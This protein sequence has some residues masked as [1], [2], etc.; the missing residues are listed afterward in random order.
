MCL[1]GLP[2]LVV[3]LAKNQ[4]PVARSLD[5]VGVARHIGSSADCSAAKLAT[6]LAKLLGSTETRI[7]MS[8]RGRELVDGRGASRVVDA[9]LN[10]EIRVRRVTE[11]DCRLLW[12]W[13]NEPGVRASA[14][15]QEAIGWE[16]HLAWFQAR[17]AD[18]DCTMVIGETRDGQAVGQV[19]INRQP[20]GEADIDVSVAHNFRGAGYG[21]LLIDDTLREVS[22]SGAITKVHAYIR[23]ENRASARAFEKAGFHRVGETQVRG[24]PAVHYCRAMSPKQ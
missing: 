11:S 7:R 22:E 2:A 3:D 21:S 14:F 1:L 12:N 19:R 6:E 18:H 13:A 16:E 15:S 9:M 4:V 23:P 20:S 17:L 10:R 24:N 8:A 5:Q